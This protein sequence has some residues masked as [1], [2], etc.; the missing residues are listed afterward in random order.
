MN[1]KVHII[2]GGTYSPVYNHVGVCSFAKGGTARR[3]HKMFEGTR[4]ESILHL[5]KMATEKKDTEI[6][7]GL[8]PKQFQMLLR[9]RDHAKGN[10]FHTNSELKELVNKLKADPETKVIVLTAAV[11]DYIS[12]EGGDDI[13]R[14]NLPTGEI[15][16][17][18]IQK[19]EKIVQ[20]I[21]DKDHKH[22][23][24]VAFKQTCNKTPREMYLAGLKLCKEAS[25]NLV[26]VND[27]ET[28]HNMIVTP[29]EASYAD[30]WERDEVLQELVSMTVARSHLSF[31]RSTVVA[32]EPVSWFSDDV[33]D[34][35]RKVV[36]W[37]RGN[38]AYKEFNGATV[39]HFAC[40]LSPTEFL[41]SIRRSNFNE[42]QRV[43][44]VRVTTDGPDN[45]SAYGAKPSVG[46]QSQRIIFD[47][48]PELDSI[49]HFH[50]P[51]K[52]NPR[53][54]I[55]VQSQRE[56]EC[57]SHECGQNTANG[58]KQ[59]GNLWAVY[60]HKH[61]P[62]IVFSKDIDPQEVID[63]IDA[64]FDLSEKTGGYNLEERPV[65]RKSAL[66]G[67]F[68]ER[69]IVDV[70]NQ[71]YHVWSDSFAGFP[72]LRKALV[73]WAAKLGWEV[74]FQDKW[75]VLYDPAHPAAHV[76]ED[77]LDSV[78]EGEIQYKAEEAV[79]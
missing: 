40:K 46:G 68:L 19:A 26:L 60:L 74:F 65:E 9:A 23:F 58:L 12:P 79:A 70:K 76:P 48:H 59:F 75:V 22:I 7:K 61:G 71:G 37:C 30:G 1:N 33:P 32:G 52:E 77:I 63:F 5:S 8:N 34:A 54:A 27:T 18:A 53:D 11:C 50:C 17:L 2:G 6:P 43:G 20:S 14:P 35:L 72:G 4:L 3:L 56:V 16:G 73:K 39:G 44:L 41:T 21:R 29:E 45:V 38:K 42:L 13:Q 69:A 25:V 28:R 31:T 51:L 64:N 66:E 57:G 24:L 55:Q 67:S 78:F 62:N 10:A 36:D 47:E 49:V 15:F